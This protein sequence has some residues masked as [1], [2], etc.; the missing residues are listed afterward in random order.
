MKLKEEGKCRKVTELK[1]IVA[2]NI[3]ELRREAGLTQLDLAEKL[4]YSDKAVSKWESGQSIPDVGVL[5]EIAN[6]FGVTVDYLLSEDHKVH[7]K[8]MVNTAMKGRKHLVITLLSVAL[9]W[10]IATAVFVVISLVGVWSASWLLFVYA[11]PV[12]A[13]LL[14]IFNSIWG[15]R[16]Q[17][18]IYI[19][20]L[21]WSLLSSIYLSLIA[22]NFW[23]IFVIGIPG[24]IIICLWAGM[25]KQTK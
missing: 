7:V 5:L 24:Q 4:N 25:K 23:L 12:S 1:K 3:A 9:V 19:S 11:I 10:L 17:N 13:V 22:Y 6:L 21:M 8:A 15:K 20:I 2:K 16:R 18:Y 14:I